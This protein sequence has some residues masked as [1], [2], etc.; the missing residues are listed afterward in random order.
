L[1]LAAWAAYQASEL[2]WAFNQGLLHN[3]SAFIDTLRTNVVRH[4]LVDTTSDAVNRWNFLATLAI[5]AAL[6]RFRKIPSSN[7]ARRPGLLFL[8]VCAVHV[9]AFSYSDDLPRYFVP[10]LPY[11]YLSATGSL[12]A[13]FG[14]VRLHSFV[15]VGASAALAALFTTHY[16]TSRSAPGWQLESN[17]DYAD[18]VETHVAAARYLEQEHRTATIVTCWP[19]NGELAEPRHGYVSQALFVSTDFDAAPAGSILYVS[20]ESACRGSRAVR[21]RVANARLLRRFEV[22][23]KRADVYRLE[24]P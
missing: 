4:F 19:M 20:P 11:F 18:S 8:L 23:G 17:L 10:I 22:R 9:A 3:R 21:R 1:P 24:S 12:A 15:V 14:S 16:R 2:G 5:V 13:L 7:E 6:V